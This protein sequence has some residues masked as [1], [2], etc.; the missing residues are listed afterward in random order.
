[1][2]P[3]DAE[4]APHT[5]VVDGR[6]EVCCPTCGAAETS[7]LVF[8]RVDGHAIRQCRGCGLMFVSPR[9]THTKLAA[10]YEQDDYSQGLLFEN[11]SYDRWKREPQF[12][13]CATTSSKVKEMLIDL[14]SDY[15]PAGA[16]LFDVGCGFGLTVLEARHRGFV[17]DGIDISE[18]RLRI[19]RERIGVDLRHGRLEEAGLPEASY[20]GVI[21]WDVL[22]HVHNPLNILGEI[23]RIMR[24]GGYLFGQVPN[25][26][27]LSNRL[28]TFLNR[29]GFARKQFKHFG[30]PHHV[31]LFDERSL[32]RMLQRAGFEL[33]YCRSWSKLKYKTLSSP[34]E[35]TF[36]RLLERRRLTDYIT[37]VGQTI[38]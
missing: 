15:L 34:W 21:F 33:V 35:R 4:T 17:A 12:N 19:A 2:S 9:L 14:V 27:G 1:M 10:I 16:R 29:H 28:K 24:S 25:W 18:H 37:F 23:H 31:C 38:R 30:I 32:R 36:Y 11:F 6:E 7:R 26:R 20:D 8:Q 5:A 22:E 13:A 3:V